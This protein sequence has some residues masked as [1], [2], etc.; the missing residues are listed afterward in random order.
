[1]PVAAPIAWTLNLAQRSAE[2]VNFPLISIF[3]ALG[4]F[5]CFQ[6][7]LHVIQSALEIV[8]DAIYIVDCLLN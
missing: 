1:M 4:Q 3:L 8:H 2:R 7:F 6:Q 5:E